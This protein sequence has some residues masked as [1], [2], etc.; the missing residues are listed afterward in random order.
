M[1]KI[2]LL[3][4]MAAIIIGLVWAGSVVLGATSRAG[5]VTMRTYGSD[6]LTVPAH[7]DNVSVLDMSFAAVRHFSVTV[8]TG[9]LRS[10]TGISSFVEV[11]IDMDGDGVCET[12][13]APTAVQESYCSLTFAACYQFDAYGYEVLA[14]NRYGDPW[15]IRVNVTM[16]WVK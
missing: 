7:N 5:S 13:C 1:K 14:S 2:A 10:D 3:A 16:T 15:Q 4:A 9:G 6:L 11:N 8:P 12:P